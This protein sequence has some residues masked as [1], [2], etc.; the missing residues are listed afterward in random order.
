MPFQNGPRLGGDWNTALERAKLDRVPDADA[1][2]VV[3]L[4]PRR[5]LANEL[6][7]RPAL[8]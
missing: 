7:N 6:A 5:E 8:T 3:R 2:V 1:A 4:L